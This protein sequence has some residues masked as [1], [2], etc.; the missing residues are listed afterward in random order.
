MTKT[1]PDVA[2]IIF[3]IVDCG[4][5]VTSRS[6]ITSRFVWQICFCHKFFKKLSP[7][8]K[9]SLAEVLIQLLYNCLLL[10]VRF[11]IATGAGPPTWP[12]FYRT[13]VPKYGMGCRYSPYR[14]AIHPFS[15]SQG[16][17]MPPVHAAT[18]ADGLCTVVLVKYTK[19]YYIFIFRPC[20]FVQTTRLA[21]INSLW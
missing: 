14:R 12:L 10:N 2:H 9:T 3:E 7:W 15:N 16:R 18:A 5:W 21:D 13:V 8:P 4:W 11:Y 17:R 19:K 1:E 6:Q 20:K